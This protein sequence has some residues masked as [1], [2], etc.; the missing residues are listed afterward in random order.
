M[1]KSRAIYYKELVVRLVM[2]TGCRTYLGIA[3]LWKD[4]DQTE[5][6]SPG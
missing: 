1:Q 4:K 3:K 5:M 6:Y 2:V